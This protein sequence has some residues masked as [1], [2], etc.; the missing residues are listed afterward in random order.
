[1]ELGSSI[2]AHARQLKFEVH[3]SS[4]LGRTQGG[5]VYLLSCGICCVRVAYYEL[6]YV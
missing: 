2:G 3:G 1:V 6:D 4:M 5:G